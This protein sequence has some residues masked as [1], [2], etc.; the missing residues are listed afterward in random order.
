MK[1]T[2]GFGVAL[3]VV[4]LAGA[5]WLLDGEDPVATLPV[6]LSGPSPFRYPIPLWD[7]RVEGETILMVHVTDRGGV[8]TAYVLGSSGQTAFDSAALAGARALRFEPAR[9]GGDSIASW[10][11]VPV[12]FRMPADSAA[13]EDA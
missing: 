5:G 13:R 6:P 10:A 8:D 9:R 7:A 2:I 11:R 1:R 4:G 3:V 12:R